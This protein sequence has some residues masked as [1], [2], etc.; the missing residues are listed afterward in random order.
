MGYMNIKKVGKKNTVYNV[1]DEVSFKKIYE[2]K[3]WVIDGI[4]ETKKV[5]KV[6]QAEIVEKNA[7]EKKKKKQSFDDNILKGD[8]NV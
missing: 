1:V 4:I 7:T 3:G 6:S 8:D 5:E 2:P